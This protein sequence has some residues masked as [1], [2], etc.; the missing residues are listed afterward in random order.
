M[1]SDRPADMPA[2]QCA[3]KDDIITMK[4]E[5]SGDTVSFMFESHNQARNATFGFQCLLLSEGFER[6]EPKTH[7]CSSSRL[8]TVLLPSQW[9]MSVAQ[10]C[11][12]TATLQNQQN[13]ALLMSAFSL[14]PLSP[15]DRIADFEL[16]LMDIDAE[17]LGI[18]DTDYS[19]TCAPVTDKSRL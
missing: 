3:A 11:Q 18:P 16:K 14:L 2:A 5:D 10:T 15:Q 13:V 9:S 4:A 6:P 19:A 12:P 1:T 7:D 8:Q 17:Q